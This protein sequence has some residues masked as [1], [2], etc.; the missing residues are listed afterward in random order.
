MILL[1]RNCL[2]DLPDRAGNRRTISLVGVSGADLQCGPT[3]SELLPDGRTKTTGLIQ[4]FYSDNESG[5]SGISMHVLKGFQQFG[6]I[7]ECFGDFALSEAV[8]HETCG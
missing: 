8:L 4:G 5:W 3:V 6:A 1:V 2:C 7:G